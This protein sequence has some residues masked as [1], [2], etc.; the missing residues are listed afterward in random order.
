MIALDGGAGKGFFSGKTASAGEN[1]SAA[2]ARCDISDRRNHA[3]V[4]RI[5]MRTNFGQAR[6]KLSC[7]E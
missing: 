6:A 2:E 1:W 3:F 4:K 5:I 7:A